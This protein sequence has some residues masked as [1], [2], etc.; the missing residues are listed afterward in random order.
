ME[1]RNARRGLIAL[2]VVLLGALGVVTLSPA[3]WAQRGGRVRG[4]YTMVSGKIVGGNANAI[5]IVDG[6]NQEVLAAR[7]NEG[8]RSVDVLGF[9][10]MHVDSQAQQGR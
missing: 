1:S 5:Y 8:T 7:W 10:D 3:S 2:N 4:D 9:R 6:A